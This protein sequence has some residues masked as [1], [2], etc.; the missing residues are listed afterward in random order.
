MPLTLNISL[1]PP[2]L[3]NSSYSYYTHIMSMTKRLQIPLTGEEDKLFKSVAKVYEI[4]AAEWAR[5]VLRKA[6]ERDLSTDI[7]MDPLEAI[8]KIAAMKGPITTTKK[9]KEQS[10]K[11]RLA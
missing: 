5:R 3:T 9:M 7:I 2:N 10:I 6:A 4:S 8:E 1:Y 11:G